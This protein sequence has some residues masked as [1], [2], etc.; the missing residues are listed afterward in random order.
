MNIT[1]RERS[2]KK[3][4]VATTLALIAI[5]ACAAEP[6][7]TRIGEQG[8]VRFAGGGCTGTT[9]MAVGSREIL[10]LEPL[11]ADA[12]P[13]GLEIR[14]TE[15]SVIAA[16]AVWPD[17]VLLQA[18]APGTS[19]V[20]LFTALGV[21]DALAFSA[22][23]ATG[24]VFDAESRV[25]E[26]GS[27]GVVVNEVYGS[28]GT[29]DCPLFGHS[30]LKWQSEPPTGL[31][32]LNDDRGMATF[33]ADSVGTLSL[34]AREPGKNARLIAHAVDVVSAAGFAGL[35]AELTTIP[36]EENEVAKTV[37]LPGKV[38]RGAVFCVR[39]SAAMD[40]GQ[41]VNISRLDVRWRVDGDAVVPLP[42]DH[43]NE[44]LGTVFLATSSAGTAVLT[45]AVD[46]LGRSK[47]FELTVK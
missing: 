17:K 33:R 45:A 28:C 1:A 34:E 24:V 15:P 29:S 20:E 37:A 10:T 5:T 4:S 13:A 12:L 31:V 9:T 46:L 44:P 6:V 42:M 26:G 19:K 35:S 38:G 36:F 39:I 11:D 7:D 18:H 40:D 8:R 32:L 2:P 16:S 43:A 3:R 21:F 30:F 27:L 14:A 25:L 47:S 22:E 23:P 41:A